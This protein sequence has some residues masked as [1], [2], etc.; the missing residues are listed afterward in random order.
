[1]AKT[2]IR[3]ANTDLDSTKNISVGL[4]SITGVGDMFSNAVCS[5]LEMEGTKKVSELSDEDIKLIEEVIADP[6]KYNIPLWLLNRRKEPET[7]EDKH[8]SGA[9]VKYIRD[10][11]IKILKKIKSYKGLRHQWGL[12]LRGQR[13]KS[14]ARRN[15]G[16]A[17]SIKRKR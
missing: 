2:L 6:L 16:K 15:K 13:N 1:M 17:A 3:I 9:N 7:G 14:K 10:E 5:V 4:T 11:D 12:T 8:L